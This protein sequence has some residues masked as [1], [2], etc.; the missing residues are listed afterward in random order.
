MNGHAVT[1][2]MRFPPEFRHLWLVFLVFGV[3]NLVILRRQ[4]Q[5]RSAERPDLAEGYRRYFLGWAVYLLVPCLVMGIGIEIG[6]VPDPVSFLRLG[7]R[8]PYITAFWVENTITL[9]LAC[10]WIFLRRGAEFLLEHQTKMMNLP[11]SPAGIRA[12]FAFMAVFWL[13]MLALCWMD[14]LPAPPFR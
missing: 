11:K 5:R 7:D 1:R 4:F 9:A 3:I 13:V 6:G 12:F 10:Y 14:I 2:P 8:N